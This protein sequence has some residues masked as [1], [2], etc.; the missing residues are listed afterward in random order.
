MKEGIIDIVHR[1][2]SYLIIFMLLLC[3]YCAVS[4]Y[5]L[6]YFSSIIRTWH[7]F[8]FALPIYRLEVLLMWFDDDVAKS[9]IA[10]LQ[11][12]VHIRGCDS[13]SK[14]VSYSLPL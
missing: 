6:L 8:F 4:S 13:R 12:A 3:D 1:F 10:Q 9:L 11:T 7:I 2:S 5:R 14:N